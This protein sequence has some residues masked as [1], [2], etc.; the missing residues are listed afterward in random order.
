V[1][2]ALWPPGRAWVQIAVSAVYI[3]ALGAIVAA[4]VCA[5][6]IGLAT[7]QGR[8][9]RRDEWRRLRL[10]LPLLGGTFVAYAASTLWGDVLFETEVVRTL[11]DAEV[12][13]SAAGFDVAGLPAADRLEVLDR[14]CAGAIDQEYFAQMSQIIPLLLIGV[15]I[16]ANFFKALVKRAV[17]RAMIFVTVLILLV[18]EALAVSAL[19]SSNQGCGDVLAR[20]HEH[21]AFIVTLEAAAVGIVM[22]A[23]ALVIGERERRAEEAER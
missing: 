7:R 19:P 23:W 5:D 8:I 2:V 6:P 9:D 22:L 10:A 13:A 3:A 1:V 11:A 17:G 18:G 15:G 16:E 21:A 14:F 12:A 20:R 4:T